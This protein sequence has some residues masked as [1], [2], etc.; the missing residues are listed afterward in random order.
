MFPASLMR[1]SLSSAEN[2]IWYPTENSKTSKNRKRLGD[3]FRGRLELG[4]I[5]MDVFGG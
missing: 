2:P 4:R 3:D 1:N 5:L